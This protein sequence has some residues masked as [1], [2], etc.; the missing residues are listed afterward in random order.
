MLKFILAVVFTGL[1]LSPADLLAQQRR[2]PA[3]RSGQKQVQ[4]KNNQAQKTKKKK[5]ATPAQL[6]K[7]L[8]AAVQKN[9][10]KTVFSL[11]NSGADMNYVDSSGRSALSYVFDNL[12]QDN[13]A[14]MEAFLGSYVVFDE[15][16]INP[17]TMHLVSLSNGAKMYTQYANLKNSF[18]NSP[19]TGCYMANLVKQRKI[20]LFR[21]LLE[22]GVDPNSTCYKERMPILSLLAMQVL[23]AQEGPIYQEAAQL[24]L[25]AGASLLATDELGNLPMHYAIAYFAP[26]S[27]GWNIEEISIIPILLKDSFNQDKQLLTQNK[28]GVTPLMLSIIRSQDDQYKLLQYLTKYISPC[29]GSPQRASS[30]CTID[31]QRTR[32]GGQTLYM[33]AAIHGPQPYCIVQK[34]LNPGELIQ[35][36]SGRTASSFLGVRYKELK[37]GK[38]FG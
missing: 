19:N 35:D 31:M 36:Y 3:N 18:H 28:D 13:T 33:I 20:D 34:R 11:L 22:R 26:N 16:Y 17:K 23:S 2:A 12:Q 29:P 1:F 10:A 5:K 14:V 21:K 4:V 6:N 27:A 15:D 24:L 38:D 32:N 30:S 25:K 9:D 8:V 37:C 7:R